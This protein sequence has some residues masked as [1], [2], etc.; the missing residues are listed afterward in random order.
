MLRA[1]QA[2]RNKLKFY[3]IKTDEVP[4]NLYV[5]GTILAPQ[6]NFKFFSSKEWGDDAESHAEYKKSVEQYMKTYQQ[7]S[8]IQPLSRS[9]LQQDDSDLCDDLI[10]YKS[11]SRLSDEILT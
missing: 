4:S 7:Q 6:H 9:A 8:E 2:G 11:I 1:L 3:Y 5:I 10:Q